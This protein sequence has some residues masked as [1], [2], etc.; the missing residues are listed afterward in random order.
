[1]EAVNQAFGANEEEIKQKSLEVPVEA[2]RLLRQA[3]SVLNKIHD[4]IEDCTA[5]V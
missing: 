2:S 5:Y 4:Y 1:V 3:D